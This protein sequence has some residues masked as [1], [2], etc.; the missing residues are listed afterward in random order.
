MASQNGENSCE[1]SKQQA[2]LDEEIGHV[3]LITLNN[4]GKLNI[5]TPEVVR[6]LAEL[7]EKWEKANDVEIII[8]KGAGRA[9]SAGGDLRT[10]YHGKAAKYV[11][12]AVH[13]MYWLVSH[14]HTY[15]KPL[16]AFVHSIAMGGGA[17][18]TVPSTFTIVTEKTVLAA[19]EARLG[20]HTDASLSYILSH[21]P[22][23]IGEYLGLTGAR[24]DGAEM[25][26]IGL[27]THYVPSEKLPDLEK[28][29]ISLNS[30]DRSVIRAAIEE[31]SV[32]VHPGERS[33]LH[34]RLLIDKCF[35]KDT[36]EEII[37]SLVA[38]STVEEN[39]WVK[40]TIKS[41]KSSSPT[42]LKMTLKSVRQARSQKLN[43]CLKKEFRMTINT[44]RG[45]IS[46][47]MY[48][49]IRA[50]VID[51][52]N[53]PKW[54]PSTLG[55]ITEE[56]LDLIFQPFEEKFE[57]QLP[58]EEKITRWEGKFKSSGYFV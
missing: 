52:D 9:F 2:V 15:K 7:Y 33:F 38:E 27:G 28:H 53:S 46:N 5:I 10:F 19:P 30:G 40:E 50:L 37:E 39:Q 14:I 48:E 4:P 35:S 47:D 57:L 25:V 42:G 54:N 13:R 32:A 24:V 51:K 18:L 43:E 56:K 3:G 16:V 20:F 21:L 23:H 26:A 49:G 31:F 45:V 29:L 36:V 6:R 8:I 17:S 41:L 11:I 34:T 44:L 22:G 12:E 58:E 55:E 1:H